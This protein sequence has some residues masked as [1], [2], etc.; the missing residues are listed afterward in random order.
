MSAV[1]VAM[2]KIE[3]AKKVSDMLMSRGIG[4][5]E[6]CTTGAAILSKVHQMDSGIV[7]CTRRF[8]DMYCNEIAQNLPDYFEMLLLTTKEGMAYCPSGVVVITMPFRVADLLSSVQ[9][10]LTQL[11]RRR[12]R[13]RSRLKRRS[14]EEQAYIDKAKEVLMERNH[15]TE[16]EAFRYIQKCSMDSCTNLV[17]TAQMILLLQVDEVGER[18]RVR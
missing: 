5:V 11:E 15:M 3:E 13:E 17:E 6:I 10:M 8:K 1:I 7:I 9:M 4:R 2:P 12:R 18:D 16:P 14:K